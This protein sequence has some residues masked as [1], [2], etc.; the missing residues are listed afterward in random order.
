MKR[1]TW[2]LLALAIF[3]VALSAV[4]VSPE[5]E[6]GG[7]STITATADNGTITDASTGKEFL[8][9]TFTDTVTLEFD[10]KPGYEFTGWDIIGSSES[11]IV[12]NTITITSISGDVTVKAESRNYSTSQG[13]IGIVDVDGLPV[14]GETLVKSW[15]FGSINVDMSGSMWTGMPCTPLIVG[16]TVYVRAG[17]ILYALDINNGTVINS[18]RSQGLGA[19]YYHYISYGNGVIFDTTGYKAYDLDL[20]VLYD[21][22]YNLRFATYHDGYMYGSLEVNGQYRLFKTSTEPGVDLENGCKIN[23]FKSTDTH[24]IWAQYG[25]YSSFFIENDWIF[26]LEADG[27]T[28]KTGYRA[29]S[30]FNIKTEQ[31]TTCELPGLTGMPWDDGWLTYYN[32]YLYVT[33]YTAGLFGGVPSGL[34]DKHSSIA[35]VKFNFDKGE[36]ETPRYQ[37]ITTPDGDKFSGIASQFLIY[38]GRGYVNVR[39]FQGGGDTAMTSFIAYDI[40]ADG[41]PIPTECANSVMTHGGIVINTAHEDEGKIH[42]YLVPYESSQQALYIF[43]DEYKDGKWTLKNSYDKDTPTRMDWGSQGIRAGPNGEII[44]Y[45][46]SGYIDCYVTSDKYRISVITM[47]G[48]SATSTYGYGQNAGAVLDKL[49]SGIQITDGKATINGKTHLIYGLNEVNKTWNLLNDPYSESYS[50]TKNSG[51]TIAP[52]RYIILLAEDSENH[53]KTVGEAGW[54]FINNGEYEKC[55]L[56]NTSSVDSAMGKLLTY[57]DTKPSPDETM[58]P[59]SLT[60]DF[61]GSKTIDLPP[62]FVSS[63]EISDE[64]IAQAHLNEISGV[65]TVNAINEGH[66]TLT[67]VSGEKSFTIDIEVLP[68]TTIDEDGNKL[69]ESD[70][71]KSTADGGSIHRV[72]NTFTSKDG[73]LVTENTVTT[74]LGPERNIIS[75]TVFESERKVETGIDGGTVTSLETTTKT[76]DSGGTLTV[77]I[78]YSNVKTVTEQSDGSIKTVTDENEL[79]KLTQIRTDT[80]TESLTKGQVT[81]SETIRKVVDN[82]TEKELESSSTVGSKDTSSNVSAVITGDRIEITLPEDGSIADL[83]DMVSVLKSG[84]YPDHEVVVTVGSEVDGG[85]ISAAKDMGAT[86][87]MVSGDSS[88]ILGADAVSGLAGKGDVSFGTVPVDTSA[89]TEGQ[90][91]AAGNA[92]VFD[93][94]V[95]CGTDPVHEFGGFTVK[96]KCV[97]DVRDG[98]APVVWRIEGDGSSTLIE[99]AT[100][101]DGE[102]S[103]DADHLSLYAVGYMPED[104]PSE[105]DMTLVIAVIAVALIAVIAGIAMWRYKKTN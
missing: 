34:E 30:A 70:T 84:K 44:Y 8:S 45:V 65:V 47:N 49:F 101:A 82:K 37:D 59:G 10:P 9:G 76:E 105:G 33:A 23:L 102:I 38:E 83:E 61:E 41:T 19:D 71:T 86:V 15:S 103:F 25:Q 35:F 72:S 36:F 94:R 5:A 91:K 6:A 27:S 50:G 39:S 99:G 26:F 58:V 18:V 77:H 51:N 68:K 96:L 14:P 28:G 81:V 57:R 17:G 66:T 73:N 52:Y 13:L 53:I 3:S 29:M 21:L 54:Y 46:D 40:A 11:K 89:L 90:K 42:I 85:S 63:M 24:K 2:A 93:I 12:G 60:I 92:L 69:V 88:I 62:T 80:H 87:I 31:Y 32:G 78:E 20:N 22:P 4:C 79:D 100:Y 74:V 16:D 7:T 75:K 43:T 56:Y 104:S 55:T 64:N 1:K 95:N 67:V 97:V 48:E 98:E